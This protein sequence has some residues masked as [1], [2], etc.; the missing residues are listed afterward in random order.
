M[1][2]KPLLAFAISLVL[3]ASTT[4]CGNDDEDVNGSKA[5]STSD[6]PAETTTT[7][8]TSP[9]TSGPGQKTSV[10]ATAPKRFLTDMKALRVD[11]RDVVQF[12]FDEG[13]PGYD[14]VYV[15][16]PLT[17]EGEGKPATINGSNIL[18]LVFESAATVDLTGGMKEHYSGPPRIT[19]AGTEV[20]SELVKVSEY[21]GR[22][23]IG[24]GTKV[25]SDFSISASGNIVTVTFR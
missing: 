4:A 8:V 14:A 17:D 16:P 21:E 19:P 24:I 13:T 5:S 12:T 9:T 22:L 18:K 3:S 20:V 15:T 25:K 1:R 2:R 11:G 7:A 10:P 23:L 6:T